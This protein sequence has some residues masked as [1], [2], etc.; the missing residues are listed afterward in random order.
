MKKNL[1]LL[2]LLLFV[3]VPFF[4]LSQSISKLNLEDAKKAIEES[5]AIYF[6]SFEKNDLSIF[7]NRYSKDACI[8]LPNGPALCGEDAPSRFFEMAYGFGLRNGKFTTQEV[9]G[10][11]DHF[12]AETGLW[13][14]YDSNNEMIDN[15][16]FLVLWKKTEEG[17]KMFRDSFNSNTPPVN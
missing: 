3:L 11:D 13:E 4:C 6:S 2:P 10:V 5:N 1:T 12:V 8:M 9:F 15:G 14:T 7:I 16:K 17:W